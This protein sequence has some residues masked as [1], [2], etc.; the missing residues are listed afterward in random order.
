[1]VLNCFINTNWLV[2]HSNFSCPH[3]N[4]EGIVKWWS[5]GHL[6][7]TDRFCLTESIWKV[8]KIHTKF[9]LLALLENWK[10]LVTWGL[11]FC[12]ES[13]GKS[14]TETQTDGLRD[15]HTQ[16]RTAGYGLAF[17]AT[18]VPTCPAARISDLCLGPEVT[19]LVMLGFQVIWV[20]W[21]GW[22]IDGGDGEG[23]GKLRKKQNMYWMNEWDFWFWA[24][25]SGWQEG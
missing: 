13:I 17:W 16:R 4:D 6:R 18:R 15:T 22:I 5:L 19:E 7:L 8:G 12:M 2:S 25:F 23:L 21:R 11:H 10:D 14:E 24:E 20:H 9:E 3:S 1:M